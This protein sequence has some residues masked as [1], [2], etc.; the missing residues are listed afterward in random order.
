MSIG[1]A[2]ATRMQLDGVMTEILQP[3]R[4]D[5]PGDRYLRSTPETVLWGRLPC[6]ADPPVLRISSG[7]SVTIDTV[8]HE[9]ILEDHG[10]DPLGYFTGQGVDAAAVLADAI[11]IAAT[12][13]RDPAADGPH[14]ITGPIHVDGAEPG[15]VLRITVEKLVPRVPYGVISNRHGKGALIGEMPRGDAHVSV[16]TP[17]EERDGR[18]VGL[19][20]IVDGGERVVAFPLAPFLGTM[21]VA[22]AGDVRPHSVPPGSHGGNIDINLLV[23]GTDLYLPVQVAGALAYVGDPHFAQGD[24]EVA[25]TALE[26]PLRATLRFEVIP[27]GEAV[28][29]FGEIT[30]P[31]VRT[32]DYLVP[33]GLDPDLNEAMRRCVRSALTL[34][35]G[36]W[37]VQEHLAYAYL[38][39]ATDFDISQVVDIVCGVHARIRES[40]FAAVDRSAVAA[41][42]RAR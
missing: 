30:G 3:G 27:R 19:L 8:S 31:L 6:A 34:I 26:A 15:D 14:I 37:G 23:E 29:E 10:K 41:R 35:E 18:L 22:V 1:G 32:P 20:P 25:L 7:T 21:G 38:S 36:R 9:G 16:F 4:G 24:G 42:N 2:G 39:A 40:D 28:A 17:V 13:A 12:L 33:T 5:L 11:E